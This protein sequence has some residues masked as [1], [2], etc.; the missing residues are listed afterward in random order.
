MERGLGHVPHPYVCVRPIHERAVGKKNDEYKFFLH[1][2][3]VFFFMDTICGVF[4]SYYKERNTMQHALRTMEKRTGR[5]N[6]MRRIVNRALLGGAGDDDKS[7]EMLKYLKKQLLVD[8]QVL[9]KEKEAAN[10]KINDLEKATKQERAKFQKQEGKVKSLKENG[11]IWRQKTEELKKSAQQKRAELEQ[12]K[13]DVEKKK[14]DILL[15]LKGFLNFVEP[16]KQPEAAIQII[17]MDATSYSSLPKSLQENVDVAKSAFEAAEQQPIAFRK[18]GDVHQIY[19]AS[20]LLKHAPET[21]KQNKE[22]VLLA[23][24]VDGCALEWAADALRGDVGVCTAAIK[25]DWKAI[26]YVTNK[27]KYNSLLHEA[28]EKFFSEKKLNLQELAETAGKPL[29][30]VFQ[31][32]YGFEAET[33]RDA[34]RDKIISLFGLYVNSSGQTIRQT[35]ASPLIEILKGQWMDDTSLILAFPVALFEPLASDEL[36]ENARFVKQILAIEPLMLEHAGDNIRKDRE[37]VKDAVTKNFM[38]LLHAHANMIFDMRKDP[39]TD[40]ILQLALSAIPKDRLPYIYIEPFFQKFQNTPYV[41]EKLFQK[42]DTSDWTAGKILKKYW[43]PKDTEEWQNKW[44]NV[45]KAAVKANASALEHVGQKFQNDKEVVLAALDEQL[46]SH[47]IPWYDVVR[48]AS[49]AMR[50]DKD[51]TDK[52]FEKWKAYTRTEDYEGFRPQDNEDKTKR[53]FIEEIKYAKNRFSDCTLDK[54]KF[55]CKMDRGWGVAGIG[56]E[57]DDTTKQC[58]R[59]AKK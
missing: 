49:E 19:I 14:Q 37:I 2:S 58:N 25:N 39:E 34:A 43:K 36:K 7:D 9:Q 51:V 38:A 42:F 46:G 12:Q 21:I 28:S 53:D 30:D 24:Q 22:I 15:I 10:K 26:K 57:W 11:K 47:R 27:D 40:D 31:M 56:C 35:N 32:L 3:R 5:N 16:Q 41:W 20:K 6:P 55:H 50:S 4:F 13:R 44:R 8:V 23:V 33:E 45:V 52:A 29:P 18:H 48:Y 54:E 17:N 59:K 1:F